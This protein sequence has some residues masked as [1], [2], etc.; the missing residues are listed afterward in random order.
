[1]RVYRDERGVLREDHEIG[2]MSLLDLQA[3]LNYLL[4]RTCETVTK[5]NEIQTSS[6]KFY[7]QQRPAKFADEDLK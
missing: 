3:L 4:T 1:M 2:A 6:L 5:M 7:T